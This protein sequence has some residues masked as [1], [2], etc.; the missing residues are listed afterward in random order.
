[1]TKTL[2]TEETIQL[3]KET[4][5]NVILND[6]YTYTDLKGCTIAWTNPEQDLDESHPRDCCRASLSIQFLLDYYLHFE[7]N[8]NREEAA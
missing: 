8:I 4:D 3:I 5:A 6:D 1:M 7:H 2:S